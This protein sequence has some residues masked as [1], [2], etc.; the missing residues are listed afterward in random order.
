MK[1]ISFLLIVLAVIITSCSSSISIV[2]KPVV[3]DAER[4][5]YSIDYMND[6][7]G[8]NKDTA[9]IDPKMIVLHWTSIP[10]LQKSFE[11]FNPAKLP[12]WRPDIK[13]AGPLN[14]AAQFLVDRDGTIY[15]LMPEDK[16]ARHVIGLNHIAIGVENVGGTVETPLTD[17]QLK[18]NVKLV[19]YLKGKFPEIEYLIGHL[20]YTNFEEHELWLEKDPKYR[21]TKIDPGESFINNARK[22]TSKY[23]WKPVPK[24]N[25]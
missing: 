21:T 14:V 19:K 1:K 25:N 20:E 7:Y 23:K 3:Y 11:A 12:N 8:L 15:R 22:K 6:R 4:E 10:T 2:D 17:E 5:Q 13:S 24:K 18:A 9:T 16:M